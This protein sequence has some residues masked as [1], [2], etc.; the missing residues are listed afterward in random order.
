MSGWKKP[1]AS[2][3]Y[4][5]LIVFYNLVFYFLENVW[6]KLITSINMIHVN[7]IISCSFL[8]VTLSIL[9]SI[10]KCWLPAVFGLSRQ[11]NHWTNKQI[12]NNNK[13]KKIPFE[14]KLALFYS[15]QP[16]ALKYWRTL[17][18]EAVHHTNEGLFYKFLLY[19]SLLNSHS[20]SLKHSQNL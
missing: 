7:L 3:K 13:L 9:A 11:T 19:A 8:F 15:L 14:M 17:D 12:N 6:E 10:N 4:I 1:Q 5:K 16:F 20:I 2:L 18:D